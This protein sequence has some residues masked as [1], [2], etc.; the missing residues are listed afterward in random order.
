MV[1]KTGTTSHLHDPVSIKARLDAGPQRTYEKDAVMGAIDGAVTTFAI[2]SGVAGAGLAS[3]VV[4][5]LG[6]ANLFADGFSMAVSNYLATR[7]ENQ[8]REQLRKAEYQAVA[9]QPEGEV[10]EIRQIFARKGFS[11][12]Q[13][14]AAVEVITSNKQRWVDT[15]LQEE[16]GMALQGAKAAYAGWVT[17]CAFAVAG[18]VPLLSFL[19][20]WAV[21]GS[22]EHP[23]FY[24]AVLT[25]LTFLF[26]GVLKGNVVGQP[27]LRA[28]L[29]TCL[30][31]SAAA[32]LAYGVGL[33]LRFSGLA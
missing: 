4:I 27:L 23:F 16:H 28:G 25:C 30:L 9:N 10:E 32:A 22:L 29:E 12:D 7:T 33:A 19:W 17:F 6:L 24:S 13:L 1:I 5:I 26:V 3:G 31:G 14:E 20:N 11:G 15:M 21:P 2:V 18:L 8:K